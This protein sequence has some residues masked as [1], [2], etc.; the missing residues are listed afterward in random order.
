M[1]VLLFYW[2]VIFVFVILYKDYV[3][4]KITIGKY[5]VFNYTFLS[6]AVF[7]HF[8]LLLALCVYDMFDYFISGTKKKI[9]I[10][11]EHM[12]IVGV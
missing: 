5:I 3:W 4:I 1:Y 11:Y 8:F 10:Y 2:G 12:P 6:L 7:F 9:K